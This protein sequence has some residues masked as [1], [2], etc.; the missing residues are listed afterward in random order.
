MLNGAFR[1]LGTGIVQGPFA[2]G[3]STWNALLATEDYAA[4]AAHPGPLVTGVAFAWGATGA[5]SNPIIKPY[6][7]KIEEYKK[8]IISGEITVPSTI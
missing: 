4:S 7:A 5:T 6:Q 8:K 3:G 1:E 2:Q